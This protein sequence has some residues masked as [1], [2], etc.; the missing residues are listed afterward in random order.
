M[1]TG[2]SKQTAEEPR[3]VRP[4]TPDRGGLAAGTAGPLGRAHM[5]A[6]IARLDIQVPQRER[7]AEPELEAG[8]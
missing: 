4:A 2:P 1:S 3:L 7:A 8:G 6:V 5:K